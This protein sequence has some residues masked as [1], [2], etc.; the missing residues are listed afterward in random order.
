M[1]KFKT[2][3]AKRYFYKK[4]DEYF[5]TVAGSNKK[6]TAEF[7]SKQEKPFEAFN[8]NMVV[9]AEYSKRMVLSYID[10]ETTGWVT[11]Y[12]GDRYF[13]HSPSAI[14]MEPT[15]YSMGM[16]DEFIAYLREIMYD[17]WK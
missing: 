4:G 12:K 3:G 9:P 11:D 10:D 15:T 14:H 17:G 1:E 5:A 16:S 6:G 8:E 13:Y 2:L 7:L